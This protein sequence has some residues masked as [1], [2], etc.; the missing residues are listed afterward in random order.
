MILGLAGKSCSGKNVVASILAEKGFLCLDMD[1]MAHQVL[2]SLKEELPPLFGPS[3]LNH[4][5]EVNR[6]HLGAMV[7]KD[8]RKLK[9]LENLLYPP[10]HKALEEEIQKERQGRNRS[11][12]IN[13]AALAKGDFWQKCDK[14]WWV[15]SPF[16]LRFFRALKRDKASPL[17]ILRRFSA[18]RELK[19][20][21]FFSKVD[22]S[23]IRNGFA[24]GSL[25]KQVES[26]ITDI[27]AER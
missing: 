9:S 24:S 15:E 21:Y 23:I 27:S 22:T 4:N 19:P 2:S 13:A 1:V 14:I 25:V 8:A 3:V 26:G 10:L 18:Q 6:K 12:V 20:Q 11:V 17:S 5:G 7:F 16:F